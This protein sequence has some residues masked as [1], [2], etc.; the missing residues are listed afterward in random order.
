M[1][2][3]IEAYLFKDMPEEHC[4]EMMWKI[5]KKAVPLYETVRRERDKAFEIVK[6]TRNEAF[7]SS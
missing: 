7:K 4:E 3:L 6:E 2:N 1:I 5:I